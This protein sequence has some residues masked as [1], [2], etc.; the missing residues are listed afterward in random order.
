M[1][2][3]FLQKTLSE[4]ADFYEHATA[5]PDWEL[6]KIHDGYTDGLEPLRFTAT[7]HYA[8]DD[9]QP[10][11][12]HPY[13]ILKQATAYLADHEGWELKEFSHEAIESDSL[14]MT[15][16]FAWMG[17]EEPDDA[18]LDADLIETGTTQSQRDRVRDVLTIVEELES[19]NDRGAEIEEV[20]Q[21]TTDEQDLDR[22]QVEHQIENLKQKGE[23]YE[24]AQGY[25]RTT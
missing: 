18:E 6:D 3:A 5:L 24:P 22:E 11:I 14:T 12:D 23:L 21:T 16:E 4:F 19:K 7:F 9:D 20:I 8:P 10:A 25:L 15:V 1:D 2:A 17:E 13:K